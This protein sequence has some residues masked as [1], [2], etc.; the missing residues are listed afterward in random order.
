MSSN[1]ELA[2]LLKDAVNDAIENKGKSLQDSLDYYAKNINNRLDKIKT[3]LEGLRGTT[4]E[5]FKNTNQKLNDILAKLNKEG[6]IASTAQSTQTKG[7]SEAA[8]DNGKQ[9][10]R[11]LAKKLTSEYGINISSAEVDEN[12]SCNITIC[13]KVKEIPAHK[14]EN[15]KGIAQVIIED[16][17][18]SIGEY[19]FCGCT[20]LTSIIIPDSVTDIGL[21]AFAAC[22]GLTS[23]TIPDSVTDIGNFAFCGCSGLTSVTIPNSVTSIGAFA[24]D[25]CSSLT[26]VIIGS[27]VT[28]IG[29][30]AFAGCSGLKSVTFSNSVTDIANDAFSKCGSLTNIYF[31]GDLKGWIEMSFV[32]KS[33]NPM[34]Y[35]ENLYINEELLQ[36]DIIIPEGTEKIGAY[37]FYGCSGLTSITIPD[38]VTSISY[39][40]FYN[41]SGLT[42]IKMV[43]DRNPIYHSA[44]N[45][46]IE[47]ATKTL[48]AGCKTSIIPND[49]S[50][51][52]IS[53]SAFEG[54][55]LTSITIPASVTSLGWCPF[56]GCSGLTSIIVEGGNPVYHSAGNCIIET[57]TKTL[58]RGCKTSVIPDDGSVTI[59]G[60][61]AFCG[62]SGLT[63]ITIPASVTYI[64]YS[65]FNGC[66][67]LT[68]VYYQG[69]LSGWLKIGVQLVGIDMFNSLLFAENLYINGELLQG[70]IVIPKGIS[71][72]RGN[73]FT[74]RRGLTSI[75]IPKSVTRIGHSAFYGCSGLTSVTIPNSVTSIDDGAFEGCSGLTSVAI[76]KRLINIG[77][78]VFEF[79]KS[80]TS[81]TIPKSVTSIE[82]EAFSGCS[83]LT[84]IN[85]QGKKAQWKAINKSSFWDDGTGDYTVYC[86][87]GE[88]RKER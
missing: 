14:F 28:I 22:S 40:A 69:D 56:S 17:V 9:F 46:L 29:S 49:G 53:D 31:Q 84:T 32:T 15:I 64:F 12:G 25:G 59:I 26:S 58:I 61:D 48:I 88:L 30:W 7:E 8:G 21:D 23:I 6:N 55:G 37:A 73:A 27:G 24:F 10:Q 16:G 66:S 78:E 36:G 33:S 34:Y 20:D 82:E 85:F 87:D 43:K 75:T 39:R 41:C 3:T 1:E 67:G 42:S 74:G 18:T 54:C 83:G 70:D 79:C 4:E 2:C 11:A 77:R 86:T 47:T 81:V 72:I 5:G 35:A 13:G 52:S 65:A 44:G 57:A 50:V 76:P 62:C 19:A 45:C 38:S 80:L 60:L 51:T 68:D 63:S 71:A